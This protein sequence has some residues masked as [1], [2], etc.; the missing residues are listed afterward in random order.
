METADGI[1]MRDFAL[2][3]RVDSQG[4][5][6]DDQVQTQDQDRDDDQDQDPDHEDEDRNS[7]ASPTTFWTKH[8]RLTVT[9]KE[10]RDHFALE[11][12]YLAYIRTASAYAQFGVTLAQLF[13][14]NNSN[15]GIEL[16][17]TLKIASALGAT[18]EG[19]AILVILSGTAYFVKQQRGLKKGWI[20]SRGWEVTA[21]IVV[22]FVVCRFNS[23]DCELHVLIMLRKALLHHPRPPRHSRQVVSPVS[24]SYPKFH[25][26]VPS[27]YFSKKSKVA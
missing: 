12:T 22:S 24:H 1:M 21:L 25:E 26:E 19:I 16:P 8:I 13:R 6:K 14:L 5:S 20:V 3:P 27:P 7:I 17:S 15:K 11:R 4:K 2:K 18:T 10:C 23:S 9:E